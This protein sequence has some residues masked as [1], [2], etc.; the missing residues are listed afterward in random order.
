MSLQLIYRGQGS[1][2]VE[3]EGLTPDWACDKSVGAIER[4]E[5]FHGNQTVALGELFSVSGDASD[6]RLD[7]EGD[8]SAVHW[9]GAH[10]RSGQIHV[11]GSAGRHIGSEM[12]GGEI[13]VDGNAGDWVGSEM[14]DGLIHV[15]GNAG[16]QVGAAYRG[17]VKGMLGGTILVDG[18]AGDEV[19]IA[20]HQGLIAIGGEAGNVVGFNMVDGLIVILGECGVRAGAGMQGGTIAMLGP[21]RPPVLD[22]FRFKHTT[23][24]ETLHAKLE[25]LGVRGLRMDRA[26]L[27]AEVDVYAGDL[28]AEGSGEICLRRGV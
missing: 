22:S 9:I 14:R 2:P 26:Q 20:M 23:A 8:L 7:F 16:N 5:I 11:H 24:S 28:V 19:G 10:L 18:N 13:R 3:V 25:E 27:P 21:T 12:R 6:K 15:R 17:S 4:L 1:L